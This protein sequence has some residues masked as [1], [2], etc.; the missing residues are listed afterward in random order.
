MSA[1]QDKYINPLT[2]F[3]FK[4]LFGSELNK[5]LLMDFNFAETKNDPEFLHQVNLKDQECKVFY[6]KLQFIFIELPK[7]KKTEEELETQFEKWLF[8]LKHLANLQNRPKALQERVFKK[9][10]EKAEIA[11]FTPEERQTYESSLK[12]YRDIKNVIDTAKEEGV[13]KGKL[14]GLKK[15][16]TERSIEIA[17][18]MK[19]SGEPLSKIIQFTGLSPEEI[20]KL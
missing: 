13:K 4:K 1:L 15:G 16:K 11:K 2:D 17:E 18:L 8:V 5:D 12:Y 6:E 20:Q 9:L 14:E 3:G 7:F 10:F 19:K